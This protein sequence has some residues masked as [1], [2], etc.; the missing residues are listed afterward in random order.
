MQIVNE[1]ESAG[2]LGEETTSPIA[3]LDYGHMNGLVPN[4]TREFDGKY[5]EEYFANEAH[6]NYD[7]IPFVVRTPKI[8]DILA[9][10]ALGNK[11]R[12]HFINVMTIAPKKIS[13]LNRKLSYTFGEHKIG[14]SQIHQQVTG[15]K[16]ERSAPVHDY[17]EKKGKAIE[18][19]FEMIMVYGAMDPESQTNILDALD[20]KPGY[21]EKGK[22]LSNIYFT[23]T[24]LYVQPDAWMKN[25]VEA[26]LCG[27]MMPMEFP[28]N[29]SSREERGTDRT[30]SE[31]SMPF[32]SIDK[33]NE[34]VR[35]VAQYALDN[36]S[37]VAVNPDVIPAFINNSD[38]DRAL[39]QQ[40]G[41]HEEAWK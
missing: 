38:I 10:E 41:F 2:V 17:V 3:N 22:L 24:M 6:I 16:R 25:V 33:S 21:V 4:L 11:L 18:K 14:A 40:F 31:F 34:A 39:S 29:V 5:Y 30:I 26:S 15:A 36:L 28:E 12:N 37:N 7:I 13:G 8:F 27:N 23:C 1:I 20:I 32:T 35:I 19:L 9:D